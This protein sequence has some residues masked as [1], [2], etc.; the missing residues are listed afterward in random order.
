MTPKSLPVP[1]YGGEFKGKC[2]L[3]KVEQISVVNKIRQEYPETWGRL[4]VHVRN[5]DEAA[6]AQAMRRRKLEGLVT[7]ASDLQIP[8]CPSFVCEMKR[9]DPAKSSISDDQLTYLTA[10]QAAGAYACIA[11]GAIAAWE[12]FQHWITLQ[13]EGELF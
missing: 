7:G 5:E 9:C 4:L 6:S 10:A 8:G 12:A 2:P 13:P 1:Y 11:F 3:E